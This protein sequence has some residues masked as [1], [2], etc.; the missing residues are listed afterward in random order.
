MKT[1][2]IIIPIIT[3]L[4][5]LNIVTAEWIS[6]N[7]TRTG[8]PSLT[9]PDIFEINNEWYLINS[10]NNV[11]TNAYKWNGTNW[12]INTQIIT[13][14][15][16]TGW[17]GDTSRTITF[18]WN[19]K[20]RMYGTAYGVDNLGFEWNG[21][22]WIRN[23]SLITGLS[24]ASVRNDINFIE[25]NNE[26]YA[27]CTRTAE[28][29]L[30]P[31]GRKW[32]GTSW[33]NYPPII[34]GMTTTRGLAQECYEENNNWYCIWNKVEHTYDPPDLIGYYWNGTSW[35]EDNNITIGINKLYSFD[36]FEIYDTR[37]ILTNNTGYKQILEEI[38]E[39]EQ[40]V[41]DEND[42]T[43]TVINT[44]VGLIRGF[45]LIAVILGLL[46]AIAIIIKLT[47]KQ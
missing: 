42:I 8:L 23:D 22:M 10:I 24:C 32:N 45:G 25:I 20:T 41:Y 47:I 1:K 30:Y 12:E 15:N 27:I 11:P 34:N 39:E 7:D 43:G 6:D 16:T 33:E 21:S 35:E 2:I 29:G 40:F 26:M 9:R 3:L 18:K 38:I 46:L 4:L 36:Y 19:N 17:S 28:G 14:D 31:S 44:G 5:C 13:F 37:Y